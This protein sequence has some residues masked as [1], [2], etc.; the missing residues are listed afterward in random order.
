MLALVS[1][2]WVVALLLTRLVYGAFLS[3]GSTRL[4]SR[5]HCV[6]NTVRRLSGISMVCIGCFPFSVV[7][8]IPLGTGTVCTCI[9]S[10][11][12]MVGRRLG[13]RHT[14]CLSR[15]LRAGCILIS[16]TRTLCRSVVLSWFVLVVVVVVRV[17]FVVVR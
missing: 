4:V 16:D 12:C 8:Y 15:R 17:V 3:P 5:G 7:V 9:P 11:M 14:G 6:V 13:S 2:V 10:G 1:W